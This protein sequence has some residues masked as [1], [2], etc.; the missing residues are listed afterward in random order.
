MYLEVTDAT[1][2]ESYVRQADGSNDGD[3]KFPL[4][5][6]QQLYPNARYAFGVFDIA[7]RCP[8]PKYLS[9]DGIYHLNA[10]TLIKH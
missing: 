2:P 8:N 1:G 9:I 6:L 4:F 5:S 7:S 10:D 3:E